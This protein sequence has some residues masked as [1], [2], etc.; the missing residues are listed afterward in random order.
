M[1]IY[2]YL[3][4][5]LFLYLSIRL[6]CIGLPVYLYVYLFIYL[7][8][9]ILSNFFFITVYQSIFLSVCLCNRHIPSH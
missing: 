3:S 7:Y 8:L 6:A 2:F 9:P 5:S 1:C 4:C